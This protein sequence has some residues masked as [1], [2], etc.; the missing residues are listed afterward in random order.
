MWWRPIN[1]YEGRMVLNELL[2]QV[3]GKLI[4]K[5]RRSVCDC[6][7]HIEIVH[8]HWSW[9][10]SWVRDL[11]KLGLSR[12]WLFSTWSWLWFKL[13]PSVMT[14]LSRNFW[15]TDGFNGAMVLLVVD[16]SNEDLDGNSWRWW[17]APSSLSCSSLLSLPLFLLFCLVD[18]HLYV[19]SNWVWMH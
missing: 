15:L 12:L 17:Q 18:T 14:E 2:Q 1:A 11:L 9:D 8:N 6:I 4:S 16:I 10:G 13:N 3:N 19:W 5:T 7:L